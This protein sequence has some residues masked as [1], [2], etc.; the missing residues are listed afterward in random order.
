LENSLG[1]SEHTAIDENHLNHQYEK[2]NQVENHV[3][4]EVVFGLD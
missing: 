2:D 4:A 1:R 3:F